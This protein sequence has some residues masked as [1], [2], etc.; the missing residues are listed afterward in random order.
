MQSALA[1]SMSTQF[2]KS[3]TCVHSCHDYDFH[4]VHATHRRADSQLP[5]KTSWQQI[6]LNFIPPETAV[7]TCRA[8]LFASGSP[9][10]TV[11]QVCIAGCV[12]CTGLCYCSLV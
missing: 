3:G 10:P 11:D 4:D 5:Q 6:L 9:T 12:H 7:D 1:F 2:W 8:S